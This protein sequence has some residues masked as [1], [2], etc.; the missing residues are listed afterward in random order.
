[1]QIEPELLSS[2][3]WKVVSTTIAYIETTKSMIMRF[4]TYF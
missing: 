2:P 1:M 4:L 3:C